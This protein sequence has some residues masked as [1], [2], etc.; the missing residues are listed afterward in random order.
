MSL[1]VS[2]LLTGHLGGSITHGEDHLTEP[3]KELSSTF[4]G[5]ENS[6]FK[7]QLKEENLKFDE[8]F[9]ADAIYSLKGST[10]ISRIK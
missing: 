8:V 5:D 1:L 10:G 4:L 9:N 7:L 6:E 3:L 2:L